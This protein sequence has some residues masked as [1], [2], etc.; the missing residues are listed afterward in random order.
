[1]KLMKNLVRFTVGFVIGALLALTLVSFSH[2]ASTDTVEGVNIVLDQ[3]IAAIKRELVKDQKETTVPVE[4]KIVEIHMTRNSVV[5]QEEIK[6]GKKSKKKRYVEAVPLPGSGTCS[7]S[8]VGDEGEI[9][10]AKHCVEGFDSFEVQT[11]D[12]QVYTAT[13][14]ATSAAHDLAV[15]RIDR[16]NTPYFSLAKSVT[17]GERI[18][19]L[20]SPLGIT[21]TLSTGVVAKIFGD[22]LFLDCGALPG[23]S[24]GPVF[25]EQGEMVGVLN[26]GLIVG[27]GVTHLNLAQNL[28][29]VRFFIKEV[30]YRYRDGH[31]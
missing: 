22:V 9:M 13:V 15:I 4:Q 17:R 19:V 25:N 10:T 23:N 29:T 21:D 24:G 20:G 1:M 18:S 12:S 3:D 7:G 5:V 8:F 28:D 14:I 31:R 30:A 11:Y 16:N 26:A 27:L 6:K 2:A